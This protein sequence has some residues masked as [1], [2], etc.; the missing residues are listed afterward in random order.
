[1]GSGGPGAL[2]G[3]VGAVVTDEAH[4]ER[5]RCIGVVN[6]IVKAAIL[7]PGTTPAEAT[8]LLLLGIDLQAAI[9]TG[10][11]ESAAIA[12]GLLAEAEREA[13]EQGRLRS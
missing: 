4:A 10:R 2:A 6:A 9:A 13:A 12:R 1:M 5:L 3:R 11:T 8:R 7:R